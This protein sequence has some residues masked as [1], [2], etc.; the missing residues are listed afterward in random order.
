MTI[1]PLNASRSGHAEAADA[2]AP[3]DETFSGLRKALIIAGAGLA[4]AIFWIV[5]LLFVVP[6]LMQ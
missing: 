1:A 4:A 6:P 2:H 5:M 3:S